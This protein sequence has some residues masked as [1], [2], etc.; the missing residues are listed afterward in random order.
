MTVTQT[1]DFQDI[2]FYNVLFSSCGADVM[3]VTQTS[4]CRDIG[5]YMTLLLLQIFYVYELL[6]IDYHMSNK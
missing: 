5:Y 6:W 3:T 1:S 2:G 4:V